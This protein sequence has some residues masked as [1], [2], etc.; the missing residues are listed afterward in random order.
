[1]SAILAYD[2]ARRGAR[3]T[4]LDNREVAKGAT[5]GSFAWITTQTKFRNADSLD[6]AGAKHYFN[7]HR[8]SHL[9]WRY[10]QDQVKSPLPAPLGRLFS[11]RRVRHS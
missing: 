8:L 7:L 5:S 4:V 9:R 3:V 2:F 6:E 10:L 1:L 11:T